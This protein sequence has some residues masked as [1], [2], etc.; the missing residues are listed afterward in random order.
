MK[1]SEEQEAS[2]MALGIPQQPPS[3]L[4]RIL[5]ICFHPLFMRNVRVTVGH[6]DGTPHLRRETINP[7]LHHAP[8]G[9]DERGHAECVKNLQHATVVEGFSP[10]LASRNSE[11]DRRSPTPKAAACEKGQGCL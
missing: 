5:R 2:T 4:L 1:L 3:A 6:K 11:H 10:S 7:Q 9:N 8:H